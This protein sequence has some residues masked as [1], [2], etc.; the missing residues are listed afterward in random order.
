MIKLNDDLIFAKGRRRTCFVHPDDSSRYV[1]TLR[2]DGDPDRRRREA[3]YYKRLRPLS[4]FDDNLRE[5]ESFRVLDQHD[6]SVWNHFPRR[7]GIHS[8]S[9][10]DGIVTDLIWDE[11]REVSKT[12]WQ[13][14]VAHGKT[15]ELQQAS[16]EG[17]FRFITR[18]ATDYSRCFGS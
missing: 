1:K 7:Y 12:V 5:L 18:S 15:I 17:L 16:T 3:G 13:Y 6:E 4:M 9:R 10:G 8:T 2:T 11:N 14:V